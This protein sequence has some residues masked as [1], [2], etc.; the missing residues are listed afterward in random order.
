MTEPGIPP[1]LTPPSWRERVDRLV[2]GRPATSPAVAAGGVVVVVVLTAVLVLVVV[3]GRQAPPPELSLPVAGAPVAAA[4]PSTTT[5]VPSTVVVHA[6][7]AVVAP[8][9]YR[10]ASGARVD[11][12]VAAAGG[13]VAGAEVD[14]LNLAAPLVDG[15]RVYV[16]MEGETVVEA[17]GGDGGA[18]EV[19]PG[20]LDLNTATADQLDELPGIGPATS[21]A[22]LEERERRGRFTAVDD[23]LDVSGIGDAKLQR[24]R[25]LVRV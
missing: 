22:I 24:L 7:G 18:N 15:Q 19:A 2:A 5:V 8:G 16:P 9:I 1:F 21:A 13:P 10:L 17:V 14:R 11:D 4:G 25:D 12:L 23:L 20:P 6:A 3:R